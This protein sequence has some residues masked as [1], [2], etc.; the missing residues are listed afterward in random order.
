MIFHLLTN[1]LICHFPFGSTLIRVLVIRY[2]ARTSSGT[3]SNHATVHFEID[4]SQDRPLYGIDESSIMH[5]CLTACI[6]VG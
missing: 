5:I 3:V 2:A 6:K 1:E 4:F